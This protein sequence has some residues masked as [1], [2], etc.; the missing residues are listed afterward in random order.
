M[1]DTLPLIRDLQELI[2][3]I[4]RRSPHFDRSGEAEIAAAARQLRARAL[5]RIAELEALLRRTAVT[6]ADRR[7]QFR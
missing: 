7:S 3:A 1:P 6:L 4:D 5:D 2:E